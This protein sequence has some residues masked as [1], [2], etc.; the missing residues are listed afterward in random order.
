MA[1]VR[2]SATQGHGVSVLP[3]AYSVITCIFSDLQDAQPSNLFRL[4]RL[5][6]PYNLTPY[7]AYLAIRA[8]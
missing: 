8:V 4:S 2:S 3:E 1:T 5:P 6:E 7:P